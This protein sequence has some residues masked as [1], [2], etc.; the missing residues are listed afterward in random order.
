MLYHTYHTY[1]SR[2]YMCAARV[3][4]YKPRSWTNLTVSSCPP[5]S[6]P[7]TTTIGEVF[8]SLPNI[9]CA[10]IHRPTQRVQR[11]PVC[12]F[13]AG[14]AWGL[15]SQ[16]YLC[17][18]FHPGNVLVPRTVVHG[19]L[20]VRVLSGLLAPNAARFVEVGA[21]GEAFHFDLHRADGCG[22]E[23]RAGTR[24]IGDDSSVRAATY[25]S[26]A[27]Q[28]LGWP[29]V[30]PSGRLRSRV[31]APA[32]HLRL[33]RHLLTWRSTGVQVAS[34]CPYCPMYD[35]STCCAAVH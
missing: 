20:D 17:V 31:C 2:V 33:Q 32:L 21:P 9:F 28:K 8:H 7:S 35:D 30:T 34:A 16:P 24:C 15:S 3:V 27:T 4:R 18:L 25:R 23:Q 22:A 26:A 29:V 1:N 14:L 11:R 6:W 5:S 10:C 12:C 13:A 19:E